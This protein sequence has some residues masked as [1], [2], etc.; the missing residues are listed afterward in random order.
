M[1]N[2]S[3]SSY[4]IPELVVMSLIRVAANKEATKQTVPSG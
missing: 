4:D 1:K 3:L 2:I